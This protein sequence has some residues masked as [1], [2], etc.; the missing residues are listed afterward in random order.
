MDAGVLKVIKR[1]DSFEFTNPGTLKLPLEE[2]YQGGNSKSRNPHMQT[3]LRMV[4]F[5]DNAGSGFPMILSVWK[6][7]GWM[8]PEL[9]EDTRLDQ[10]TL[11]LKMIEAENEN[12]IENV[13]ENPEIE[14]KKLLPGY[15]KKKLVKAEE[16]LKMISDDPQISFDDLRLALNVSDRTIARY[17]SEL[18]YSVTAGII[19]N[20]ILTSI[21][22]TPSPHVETII[23]MHLII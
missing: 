18:I 4:G 8:E 17:I 6:D 20:Q 9:I 16:I 19:A 7:N 14:L 13:I 11:C 1:S 2:I 3:M 12:V 5:G 23:N 22:I 15:S 10:V 21:Y